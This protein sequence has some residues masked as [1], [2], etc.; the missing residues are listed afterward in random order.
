MSISKYQKFEAVTINRK[1]IKNATYNPRTI[2]EK[3]LKALRKSLKTH[4]L[5]ETLVWNKN[6]GNLV[7]GHQRL[8]Q[9]DV[10]EGTD[11]YQLTV[12]QIDVPIKQEKEINIALNNQDIQGTYD[13]V[14]LKGLFK[15]I[16]V[17][18]TFFTDYT[19]SFFGIEQDLEEVEEAKPK[20]VQE[21]EEQIERIKEAK[22]ASKEKSASTAENYIIVTFTTTAAKELFMEKLGFPPDDR[23]VKGELLFDKVKDE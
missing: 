17:E 12:A 16:D 3:E 14:A 10:L 19:L 20:S 18:N 8:S 15:D 22:A 11:D 5:V 21:T 1:L 7:G 23:Y 4:G 6:T 2:G 13:V 9:L